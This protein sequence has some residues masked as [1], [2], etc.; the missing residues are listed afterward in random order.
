MTGTTWFSF[1]RQHVGFHTKQR[2][3]DIAVGC[4]EVFL[5]IECHRSQPDEF[6]NVIGPRCSICSSERSDKDEQPAQRRKCQGDLHIWIEAGIWIFT[7]ALHGSSA[8]H[9][10]FSCFCFI[11]SLWGKSKLTSGTSCNTFSFLKHLS[12]FSSIPA[13]IQKPVSA[14]QLAVS[15]DKWKFNKDALIHLI[16]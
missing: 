3:E 11:I 1:A 2:E 8:P 10:R 4:L 14:H 7:H 5:H 16:M 9:T 13:L 6:V 15:A 12:S